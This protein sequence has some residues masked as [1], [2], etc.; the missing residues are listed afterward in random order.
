MIFEE[1]VESATEMP[2][3]IVFGSSEGRKLLLNMMETHRSQE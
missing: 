2:P 3:S 1:Q